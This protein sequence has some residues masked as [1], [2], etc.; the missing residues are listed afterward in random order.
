MNNMTY[1]IILILSFSILTLFFQCSKDKGFH[2]GYPIIP[3]VDYVIPDL[4]D[5][6]GKEIVNVELNNDVGISIYFEKIHNGFNLIC[7]NRN[8]FMITVAFD[9]YV[10]NAVCDMEMPYS[11]VI[12]RQEI[13]LIC[14]YS[15]IDT[16]EEP[17]FDSAKVGYIEGII[18]SEHDDNYI[19]T[20]PYNQGESYTIGQGYN[21]DF[22]HTG[23]D[24]GYCLDFLMPIGTKLLAAREG[25]VCDVVQK[26]D[27]NGIGEYFDTLNNFIK[28]LH[29]DYSSAIYSH[30]MHNG[31]TVKKGDIIKKGEIIGYSGNV[32]YT[33]IPHLH[34]EVQIPI[35]PLPYK[36]IAIPT[37]FNS[38]EG[39]GIYLEEG[40]GYT[41][42]TVLIE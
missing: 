4:F 16:I 27:T 14:R 19:Y 20:L 35:S 1:K 12:N 40:H 24:G 28:I 22:T 38:K 21:S 7:Q 39:I 17:S 34:F 36:K 3:E 37:L 25:I 9:D 30:I 42:T 8:P 33:N 31:A 23:N 18:G 26:H 13:Y 5:T 41:S 11:A 2:P 15:T 6:T 29:E 10:S 32:G